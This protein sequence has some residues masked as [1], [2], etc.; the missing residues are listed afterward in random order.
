MKPDYEK[1]IVNLMSSIIE[2]FQGQPKYP[3][4]K[5]FKINS[6]NVV[7]LVLDGLGTDS[8]MKLPKSSILR[9]NYQQDL[10]SVFPSTTATGVTTFLTGLSPQ[11]HAVTGWYMQ[12]KEF[13]SVVKILPYTTKVN[14]KQIKY[15]FN[16]SLPEPMFKQIKANSY[17]VSDKML[18]E[19]KY[20]NFMNE[21]AEQVPVKTLTSFVNKIVTVVKK[22]GSN[23]VYSY[24]PDYDSVCHDFGK[25]SKEA[26]KT[27]LM[28][29]DVVTMLVKK[30]KGT[31]TELIITADHGQIE[32]NKKKVCF[33]MDHPQLKECLSQAICG[34]PRVV[35][36][37]VH[38]RKVKQFENYVN[39]RLKDVCTLHCSE[40]LVNEGYFGKSKQSHPELLNRIGDYTLILKE[41]QIIRDTLD[42]VE[43]WDI[44]NHG[45]TSKEEMIVPLIKIKIN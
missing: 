34:E 2:H 19:S 24:L 3:A 38:P 4:L 21:G 1:S 40:D 26:K 16:P 13:A 31:N 28:L 41:N 12:M 43:E 6:E 22:K 20:N 33:L 8:L 10:T 32:T 15:D 39:K 27:L 29:N 25:N 17:V 35:Y 42:N 7:L 44:G 5:N 11:D 18:F 14:K 36:C 30:L 23:Y 9:K 37:Y 45:G